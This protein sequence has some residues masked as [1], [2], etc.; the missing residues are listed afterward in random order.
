M[1]DTKGDELGRLHWGNADEHDEPSIV[2]IALSDRGAI[3][4]H[5]KRFF[6]LPPMEPAVAPRVGQEISD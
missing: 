3:A 4:L 2:E 5:E 1:D 6:S